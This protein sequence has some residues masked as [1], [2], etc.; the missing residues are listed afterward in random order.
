LK[1]YVVG[2]GI[3]SGVVLPVNVWGAGMEPLARA[4]E[5]HRLFV[6]NVSDWSLTC[7]DYKLKHA[8]VLAQRELM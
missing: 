4:S 7:G 8:S 3:F 6:P 2:T 1:K 5:C